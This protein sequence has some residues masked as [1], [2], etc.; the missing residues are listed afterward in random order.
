MKKLSKKTVAFTC[1]SLLF[2]LLFPALSWAQGGTEQSPVAQFSNF[3]GEFSKS[4]SGQVGNGVNGGVKSKIWAFSRVLMYAVAIIVAFME[5]FGMMKGDKKGGEAMFWGKFF[6]VFAMI[7]FNSF[8]ANSFISVINI[9]KSGASSVLTV[10]ENNEKVDEMLTAYRTTI[11]ESIEKNYEK[12]SSKG[13]FDS[14]SSSVERSSQRVVSSIFFWVLELLLML[15]ELASFFT[16]VFADFLIQLMVIFFPLVLTLS[17]IPGFSQGVTQYVKYLLSF[18][19][20][21]LITAVLK[22]VAQGIG[23]ANILGKLHAADALAQTG[24][25]DISSLVSFP[26]ILA[27]IIMIFMVSMTPM[28]SDMLISGSQSG[29]FFSSTVGKAT[30]LTG[31]AMALVGGA[32]KSAGA[33]TAAGIG[34]KVGG[35]LGSLGKNAGVINQARKHAGSPEINRILKTVFRN[36]NK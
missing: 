5:I 19:L 15:F 22:M 30:A 31:G 35:A 23:F 33:K 26:A 21:P 18:C 14:V 12:N 2:L 6:L 1:F 7:V 13:W 28:I 10:Q 4:I 27:L 8:I 25:L 11:N 29:G 20:W 32:T 3:L 17:F 24:N 36:R 34:G 9:F 16:T